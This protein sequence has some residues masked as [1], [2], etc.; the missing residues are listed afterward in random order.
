MSAQRTDMLDLVRMYD[1]GGGPIATAG[2]T[3]PARAVAACLLRRLRGTAGLSVLQL[4]EYG[5]AF[6]SP[7]I[8]MNCA[9]LMSADK[10]FTDA[11][12]IRRA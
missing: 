9:G 4:P 5:S 12:G 7:G 11:F 2:L 8:P 3:S 6:L 1:D 10:I